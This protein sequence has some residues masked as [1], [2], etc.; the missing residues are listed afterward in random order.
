[1][2][3]E[4]RPAAWRHVFGLREA[5]M[6]DDQYR[7]HLEGLQG[8]FQRIMERLET[9]E[10]EQEETLANL[11]ERIDKDVFRTDRTL[12]FYHPNPTTIEE[13][14]RLENLRRLQQ[15]LLAYHA[16][17]PELD[18]VQGMAD[19]L[20]PILYVLREDETEA[21]WA[22]VHLMKRQ[23]GNFLPDSPAISSLMLQAQE[24]M[25]LL[26]P[27]FS[28]YLSFNSE[29]SKL[30]FCYR[31]F[32]VL[33]K[34]EFAYEDTLRVWET[35]MTAPPSDAPYEV[36]I[37][38]ALLDLAKQ[39]IMAQSMGFGETLAHL[40]AMSHSTPIDSVLDR[41]DQIHRLFSQDVKLQWLYRNAISSLQ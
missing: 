32:L 15:L 13:D 16:H 6:T 10:T 3:E 12:P 25:R 21:F 23:R 2:E 4:V 8:D 38:A 33:F 17:D 11:K 20:S 30:F 31:W 19:L 18:Y 39:D 22:F 35:I 9:L 37:A 1:M 40:T 7:E 5:S 26:D 14:L 24:L 27:I 41:A 28:D 34:R 29:S 36:Y